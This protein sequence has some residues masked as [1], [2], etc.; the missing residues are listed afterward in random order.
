MNRHRFAAPIVAAAVVISAAVAATSSISAQD[1]ISL[2]D[3]PNVGAWIVATPVGPALAVFHPDGTVVQGV[4]TTQAGPGGVTFVSTEVGM[5]EP[6]DDRTSTS[7]P[8]SCSPTRPGPSPAPSRSMHSTRSARTGRR[9]SPIPSI[10]P[11]PSETPRTTSS[12][13][14]RVGHPR[15][16]PGWRWVH[17]ASPGRPSQ[18]PARRRSVGNPGPRRGMSRAHTWTTDEHAVLPDI[19]DFRPRLEPDVLPAMDAVLK[20]DAVPR[21]PERAGRRQSPWHTNSAALAPSVPPSG[22]FSRVLRDRSRAARPPRRVG[23]GGSRRVSADTRSAGRRRTM[24][25]RRS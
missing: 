6:V 3:H 16:G 18:P 11:S 10:R 19:A 21:A 7:R 9:S 13:S 24:G 14:S 12:T 8:C 23:P 2:A 1:E 22:V 17:L 20:R 15:S 5:W 4:T 25:D